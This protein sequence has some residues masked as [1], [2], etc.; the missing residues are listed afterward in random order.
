MP[1]VWAVAEAICPPLG[2]ARSSMSFPLLLTAGLQKTCRSA[3]VNRISNTFQVWVNNNDV[4]GKLGERC[5][6]DINLVSLGKKK[7]SQEIFV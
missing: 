5:Y 7:N 4:C 3:V 1:A 6:P 2:Q